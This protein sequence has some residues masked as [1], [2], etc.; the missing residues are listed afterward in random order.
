MMWSSLLRK[1]GKQPAKTTDNENVVA[2]FSREELLKLL[3]QKKPTY[4]IPLALKSGTGKRKMWFV[5]NY[6]KQR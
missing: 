4:Q 3:N 2:V 1:I 6:P 5:M